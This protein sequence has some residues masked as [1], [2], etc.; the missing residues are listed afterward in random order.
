MIY[1]EW[2]HGASNAAKL[3]YTAC[4]S[5][6]PAMQAIDFTGFVEFLAFK[7]KC[8]APELYAT[9]PSKRS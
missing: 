3:R 5:C 1:R 2:L 6:Q 4:L 9:L 7:G 8:Y